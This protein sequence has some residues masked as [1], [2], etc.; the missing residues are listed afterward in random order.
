M[1]DAAMTSKLVPG[2]GNIAERGHDR[3]D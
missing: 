3:R 2:I 1:G